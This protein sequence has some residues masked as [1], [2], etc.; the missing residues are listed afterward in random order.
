MGRENKRLTE[1]H[2][3]HRNHPTET[4]VKQEDSSMASVIHSNDL[5]SS[6][7]GEMSGYAEIARRY[8]HRSSNDEFG[9]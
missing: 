9:G 3:D 2:E 4:K 5:G 7:H 8:S 1:G 6:D